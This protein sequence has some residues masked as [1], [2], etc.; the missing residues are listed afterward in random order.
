MTSESRTRVK[1]NQVKKEARRASKD[2]FDAAV[3]KRVVQA[4]DDR[5]ITVEK[6]AAELGLTH[7]AVSGWRMGRA[8]IHPSDVRLIAEMTGR[9]F[10]WLLT[11]M[12][13]DKIAAHVTEPLMETIELT[14]TIPCLARLAGLKTGAL[15]MGVS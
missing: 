14:L 5:G 11:G 1:S 6:V 9:D 2:A 8:H 12:T 13:S 7:G 10:F 3:G 4:M 15:S